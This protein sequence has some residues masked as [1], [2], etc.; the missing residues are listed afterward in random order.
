VRFILRWLITAAALWAATQFVSGI[1]FDGDYR[2]LFAVAIVFG[3]LNAVVRPVLKLLTFP[4]LIL[5]LGLFIFVLNA[6]MLW[7]TGAISDALGL[8]FHVSGFVA[9]FKGALVVSI[10][11]FVLSLFVGR[12][13]KEGKS[14]R[15]KKR[16]F[17]RT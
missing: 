13:R 7:L 14:G 10:V 2:L 5:T 4:F 15:E 12:D 3:L 16:S 6:V 9:A 8:G 11:S 17:R 1:S